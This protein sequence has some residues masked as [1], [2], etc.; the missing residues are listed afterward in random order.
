MSDNPEDVFQ[1]D[2]F[3]VSRRVDAP[4]VKIAFHRDD[5]RKMEVEIPQEQLPVF[6]AALQKKVSPGQVVPVDPA[7]MALGRTYR[8]QGLDIRG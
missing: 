2:G 6:M 4:Y 1:P 8:V 5:N 3:E 7:S